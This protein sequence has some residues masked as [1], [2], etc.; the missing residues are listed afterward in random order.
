[1]FSFCDT[2]PLSFDSF[3]I[4]KLT[5]SPWSES[6]SELFRQSRLSTTLVPTFADGWCHVVSVTDPLRPYSLFSRPEPLLFLS[7]SLDPVPDTLLLTKS[8]SS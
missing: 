2:A 8:G 7:S 4:I 1:M 3:N 6:A 5:Y